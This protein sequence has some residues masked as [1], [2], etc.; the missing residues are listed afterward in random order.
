MFISIVQFPAIKEDQDEAFKDWFK[1]SNS[2]F[3]KFSG[4]IRRSLLEPENGGTYV[5]IVEMETKEA[6]LA[7]HSS[8][9]HAEAGKKWLHYSKE[10]RSPLF[11][12]S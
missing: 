9:I 12:K 1:W 10:I 4:F 2:E 6:F 5:A 3:R 7:M 8:P 11:T